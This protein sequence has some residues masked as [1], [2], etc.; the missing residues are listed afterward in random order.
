MLTVIYLVLILKNIYAC[1]I[2]Y[3]VINA[4]FACV[5]GVVVDDGSGIF[6]Y[7]FN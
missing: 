4:L 3:I 2:T 1:D 7:F 6:F 5:W